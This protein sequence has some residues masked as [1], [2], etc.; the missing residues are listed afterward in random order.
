M[1]NQ[2]DIAKT[3]KKTQIESASPGRLIVLLYEGAIDFINRC[4]E[5]HKR[6]AENW[7]EE[8]HNNC[9]RAQNIVTELSVALDMEKGGDISKNLMRLYEYTNRRLV[10]ANMTKD[11]EPMRESRRLLETLLGAWRE[12]Q[13]SVVQ[14]PAQAQPPAGINIQG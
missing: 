5:A 2:S 1:R 13:D 14:N 12:V 4:E 10:E 8:F 6:Q 3:Y 9:I 7:I 11:L